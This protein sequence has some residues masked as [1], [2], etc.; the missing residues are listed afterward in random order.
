MHSPM[1]H[2]G[3]VSV[4][5]VLILVN[6]VVGVVCQFVQSTD[7]RFPL[8]Y[9]SVDSAVL[10]A[11]AAALTLV[12]R[13]GQWYRPIRLTAVVGVLLSAIVFAAVIAPATPT[14]TWFQPHDD[15]PVRTATLLIHG[16]APILVTIEYLVRPA[17]LSPRASTLWGY[18]WPLAYLAGVGLLAGIL[19]PEMVP[20]PFLRPSLTGWPTVAG[21]YVPLLML[22]GLL[23]WLLGVLGRRADSR[24]RGVGP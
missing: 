1:V 24:M 19:G 15:M 10:A 13:D 7:P 16:V 20:Y 21:A 5:S 9:F 12:G 3:R 22:V 2:H 4:L 6:Q 17:P 18:A 14:G 11:V 8:L 23:G